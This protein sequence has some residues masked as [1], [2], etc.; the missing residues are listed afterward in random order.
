MCSLA[1]V[2]A[3]LKANQSPVR[4]IH[5]SVLAYAL[6]EVFMNGFRELYRACEFVDVDD[7][8]RGELNA[9]GHEGR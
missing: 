8:W 5:L 4:V 7:G 6:T 3:Q 1:P 2:P 9:G